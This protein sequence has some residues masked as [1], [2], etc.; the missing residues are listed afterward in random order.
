MACDSLS[1]TC[2]NTA[3]GELTAVGK[4]LDL[5]GAPVANYRQVFR[6]WRGSRVLKISIELEPLV[7]L[8]S[9]PW[10]SYFASR[11]AWGEEAVDLARSVHEQ[12]HPTT[13][14]NM[15]APHFIEVSHVEERTTLLTG[16]LPYH[17]RVAPAVIDSLLIV[18]GSKHGNLKS[19]SALIY[20]IRCTK[21]KLY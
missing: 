17:R 1:V 13:A 15:E 6:A 3:C 4:L 11:F 12:Y 10:T 19:D 5:Q 2:A 9:D 14:K 18:K 8:K 21:Q 7:E 20:H 16:G